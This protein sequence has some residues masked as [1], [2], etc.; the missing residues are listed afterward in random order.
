MIPQ[1]SGVQGAVRGRMPTLTYY[2]D[3]TGENLRGMTDGWTAARQAAWLIL[4][5]ERYEH[6]IYSFHYGTELRGLSGN[7]DSFLFPEIKRRVTEALMV[8]DRITGTSDFTFTRRR[9]RVAVRFTVHT[10]YGDANLA[11]EV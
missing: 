11:L 10:V 9:M 6:I 2:L 4:H 5:T 1:V 3:E 8:D 7:R